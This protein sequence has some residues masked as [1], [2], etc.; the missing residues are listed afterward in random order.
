M[1]PASSE[2][3]KFPFLIQPLIFTYLIAWNSLNRLKLAFVQLYRFLVPFHYCHFLTVL[4][5]LLFGLI[6]LMDF[7]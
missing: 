5:G 1:P 3:S 4:C 7:V 6:V 2:V